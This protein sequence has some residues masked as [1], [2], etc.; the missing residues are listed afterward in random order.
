MKLKFNNY[1]PVIMLG[2]LHIISYLILM[3]MNKVTIIP[4]LQS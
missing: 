4:I 2:I 3:K 1:V